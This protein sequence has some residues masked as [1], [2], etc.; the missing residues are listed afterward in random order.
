M[1]KSRNRL[2]PLGRG[3]AHLNF[4]SHLQLQ[5]AQGGQEE[6]DGWELST[7]IF[8]VVSP[9]N[10]RP[11]A[12]LLA[13][14]KFLASFFKTPLTLVSQPLGWVARIK[15][16]SPKTSPC[17]NSSRVCSLGGGQAHPKVW[18]SCCGGHGSLPQLSQHP[19]PSPA[20]LYLVAMIRFSLSVTWACS[21]ITEL[22]RALVSCGS[23]SSYISEE[24]EA[25]RHNQNYSMS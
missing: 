21:R 3:P 20:V 16:P 7:R 2:K 22:A 17:S 12:D 10:V 6:V 13:W 4:T 25:Q 18:A 11:P 9:A 1:L 23:N 15:T 5:V 14:A 19:P 24:T 8:T